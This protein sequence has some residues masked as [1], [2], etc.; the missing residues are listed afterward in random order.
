MKARWHMFIILLLCM[1][2]AV[3]SLFCMFLAILRGSN[4]AKEIALQLDD[5]INVALGGKTDT[6]LSSR[7]YSKS[8]TSKFWERARRLIDWVFKVIANEDHHCERSWM[9]ERMRKF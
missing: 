7:A 8:M 6:K 1:A 3:F 5:A 2:A 9:N 4:R